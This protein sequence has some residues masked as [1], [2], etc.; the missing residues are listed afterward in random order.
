MKTIKPLPFSNKG[1]KEK[2]ISIDPATAR[3]MTALG[4][5]G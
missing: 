5:T 3:R 4:I 1:K 2:S